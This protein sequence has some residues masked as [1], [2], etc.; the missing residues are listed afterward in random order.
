MAGRPRKRKRI[1]VDEAYFT[2]LEEKAGMLN[3][4]FDISEG[5]V[6]IDAD[7][8]KTYSKLEK[9]FDKLPTDATEAEEYQEPTNA[10]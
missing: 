8:F 5:R 4:M 7:Y 1:V 9:D 6:T 10:K 3:D 2:I